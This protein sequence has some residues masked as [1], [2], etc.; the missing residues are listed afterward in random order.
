M[1]TC[2]CSLD[3]WTFTSRELECAHFWGMFSVLSV[4]QDQRKYTS[5]ASPIIGL[6]YMKHGVVPLGRLP[7]KS[8][9][10]DTNP[11]STCPS[12]VG[13]SQ[14][15][16]VNLCPQ[17]EP[18]APFLSAPLLIPILFGPCTDA[19][20]ALSICLFDPFPEDGNATQ[21]LSTWVHPFP[22]LQARRF[23][24]VCYASSVRRVWYLQGSF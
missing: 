1:T 6:K 14:W 10:T 21:R 4:L 15:L 19:H 7:I 17:R 24:A 2:N 11:I 16:P 3:T 9:G 12:H 23:S 18:G 13:Y 20:W 22:S 5:A 8:A